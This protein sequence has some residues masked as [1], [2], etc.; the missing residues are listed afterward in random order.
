MTLFQ[1]QKCVTTFVAQKSP[2]LQSLS[3]TMWTQNQFTNFLLMLVEQL[4]H[5]PLCTTSMSSNILCQPHNSYYS[6]WAKAFSTATHSC[7]RQWPCRG[8]LLSL[9]IVHK[10]CRSFRWAPLSST[11]GMTL[12][13][14]VCNNP[15][16]G[17]PAISGPTFTTSHR[18][19]P[20]IVRNTGLL[21]RC[22]KDSRDP[23]FAIRQESDEKL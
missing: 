20:T 5:A 15:R 8:G 7:T 6:V 1:L 18:A 3:N 10:N 19:Q 16:V 13:R 17:V 21:A 11:L 12:T 22:R 23:P 2:S 9:T 14:T 4:R